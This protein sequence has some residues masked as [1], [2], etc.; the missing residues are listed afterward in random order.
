[1][2]ENKLV[3]LEPDVDD[4]CYL[5][6]QAI[7]RLLEEGRNVQANHQANSADPAGDE[8]SSEHQQPEA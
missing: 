1:M 5:L 4:L 3:F 6:G 7:S 8:S 2:K